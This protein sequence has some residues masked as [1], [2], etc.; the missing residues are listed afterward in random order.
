M[1]GTFLW[2]YLYL[3]LYTGGA[4]AFAAKEVLGNVFSGLIN[5]I[6]YFF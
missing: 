1:D 6:S 5:Q 4:T 3:Y 2:F